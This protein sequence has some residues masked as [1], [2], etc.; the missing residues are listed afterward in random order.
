MQLST[1]SWDEC[2]DYLARDDRVILPIG[3]TEEHGRHLGLGC[4]YIIA[5]AIAREV[6]ERTG[7]AVAPVL[8]YGMS[9]A[10]MQFPG[11]LSLAPETLIAVLKDLIRSL[12]RHGFRRVLIVNGHGGN[13]ASIHSA[14]AGL[15]T[16]FAELRIKSFEWWLKPDIANIVDEELGAQRGTHASN[17][18]TA[19][20]M[21]VQPEGVKMER[22]ARRDAAVEPSVEFDSSRRFAEKYPDGVMGLEPSRATVELGRVLLER[23]VAYCAREV[24]NW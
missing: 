10:L 5:E 7:V 12:Y 15:F 17:H 8:A 4:D 16:E 3:A 24:E 13:Q 23:S 11:T 18:E 19:F 20:L 1:L 2:R 21:A 6:G 22:V 9:H 14:A